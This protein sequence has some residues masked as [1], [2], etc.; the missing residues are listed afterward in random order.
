MP[1][2]GRELTSG[3]YIKLDD[4]SSQFDGSTVTFDLKSGGNDFYPGSSFSLLVSVA[5]IIQEAD[6]AYQI[7]NNQITFATAPSNGDDGFIIVLGLA[8]GIGVPGDGTVGLNQLQDNAKL[9]ISTS[10]ANNTS[11]VSVGGA[12]TSINFAG[13][14]VTTAFVTPSTGIATIFF[15]GDTSTL[16]LST[17]N[18][19]NTSSVKVGAAVTEFNFAG[20]G[21]TTAFVT[22]GIATVFIQGSSLGVTTSIGLGAGTTISTGKLETINFAGPGVSTGYYNAGVGIATIF[23]E[24]G[25]GSSVGAAGTWASDSVGV[26]TSKVVGVGTAAAVGTAN[27]EGALQSLGNIAITDGALLIDNDI[28]SNVFIPSGKNGLLIGTVSVAVGAT[29]DVATGSVLVVV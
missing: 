7:E 11:T 15:E 29:I 1:Y 25:G 17:S 4:I 3:N 5:G 13:P 28:S 19:N 16:G 14:G 10:N 21:V 24:G 20:P 18:S 22:G 8:L 27:S 6:S 9:G 26:A 23:F 2:L 12:V